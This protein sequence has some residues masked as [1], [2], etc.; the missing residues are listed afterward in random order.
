MPSRSTVVLSLSL[1]LLL[2]GCGSLSLPQFTSSEA[3][4]PQ[5][6]VAQTN[7]TPPE[8][9]LKQL[10]KEKKYDEAANL[11]AS[12]EN[13]LGKDAKTVALLRTVTSQLNGRFE[14]RINSVTKKLRSND[15]S[16]IGEG[17]A[18]LQEYG[19]IKLLQQPGNQLRSISQLVAQVEKAKEFQ[20]AAAIEKA[21][22]AS[23]FNTLIREKKYNDAAQLWLANPQELTPQN[24]QT[25]ASFRQ[26]IAQINQPLTTKAEALTRTLRTYEQGEI[27]PDK[28]AAARSTLAAAD[29]FH[30]ELEQQPLLA[31]KS[32]RSRALTTFSGILE[33]TRTNIEQ[34]DQANNGPERKIRGML[35]NNQLD[36]A[37]NIAHTN[38]EQLSQ[39]GKNAETLLKNLSSTLNRREEASLQNALSSLKPHVKGETSTNDWPKAKE[40]LSN[41][42]TILANYDR[43]P[44]L[45]TPAYRSKT[46]S[47]LQT[48]LESTR[49]AFNDKAEAAFLRFKPDSSSRFPDSY[50]VAVN[51]VTLL[52]NS[53][54][55][56]EQ[57][58]KTASAEQIKAFRDHYL[59][60]LPNGARETLDAIYVAAKAPK[61]R[62]GRPTFSGAWTA[63]KAAKQEGIEVRSVANFRPIFVHLRDNDNGNAFAV[64]VRNDTNFTLLSLS[65]NEA[66]MH[67][68]VKN[69]NYVVYIG[70]LT[71]RADRNIISRNRGMS[72]YK[73]GE[74]QVENPQWQI[75]KDAVE[76]AQR[77]EEEHRRMIDEQIA[78][79]KKATRYSNDPYAG[80]AINFLKTS[81]TGALSGL[82]EARRQLQQ[83]PRYKSEPIYRDYGYDDITLEIR[84]SV[85]GNVTL[86]DP[87]LTTST[88]LPLPVDYNQRN[89]FHQVNNLRDDD[90]NIYRIRQ[91]AD[92]DSRINSFSSAA[93]ELVLSELIDSLASRNTQ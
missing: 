62:T 38:R 92:D 43:H 80:L 49:S 60:E 85:S 13:G 74:R 12:S 82:T 30:A 15:A 40:A 42:A 33:K 67:P 84:R 5:V 76:E 66:S 1:P 7:T 50:P 44:L 18:I 54:S 55:K 59:N 3:S 21:K 88:H 46:A 41:A 90:P 26:L 75:A 89:T 69:A 63:L 71:A 56:F 78:Q 29:S 32:L 2:S 48:T 4:Q 81:T 91:N 16:A 61:D 11:F 24:H 23:Q 65:G 45:Q 83:T 17:E 73:A 47:S 53:Q 35:A 64:N 39:A 57:H 22:P 68:E 72:N 77:Q 25:Q 27:L 28:I 9:T 52:Q 31:D 10:V 79:S 20:T 19:Q 34:N 36:E 93:H 58:F 8:T 14:K 6:A 37:E 51:S 86:K 87:V 70:P